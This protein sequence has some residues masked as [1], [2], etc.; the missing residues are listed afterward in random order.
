MTTV[1][2]VIRNLY[3]L[4]LFMFVHFWNLAPGRYFAF[5]IHTKDLLIKL[6]RREIT[7]L[8]EIQGIASGIKPCPLVMQHPLLFEYFSEM[9]KVC[10][11]E[12]TM[13]VKGTMNCVLLLCRLYVR[14]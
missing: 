6:H 14:S 1:A 10:I 11:R 3:K 2:A 12:F 5:L 7:V 4:N 13:S 8:E 9:H